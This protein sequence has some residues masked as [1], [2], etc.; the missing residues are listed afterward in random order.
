MR[1]TFSKIAQVAGIALALALTLSCSSDDDKDDGGA[2]GGGNIVY[3]PS[4]PYE[5]KT[6]KTV[7]IGSQIWMA[8]NLN[9]DVSGSRCY[10]DDPANCAKYGRLYDWVTAMALSPS[11]NSTSCS[12][13]IKPKHQGIC[14]SGW[15]IP[16]DADWN[17]LMKHVNPSCSDNTHCEGAGT[18]LKSKTGWA[19]HSGVLAGTDEYGF[20]AL[21]GGVGDSRDFYDVGLL[22][23]WWSASE[24]GS[25]GAYNRGMLT[26]DERMGWNYYGKWYLLSVRCLED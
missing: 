5:G 4:V 24:Y 1:S 3:G 13:D 19:Q 20:S 16:S 23:R 9:Y 6:Y 17:T 2:G 18:K 26:N 10:N 11:C 21:P 14:P 25:S 12:G 8:E 22:G 7:K 15:H